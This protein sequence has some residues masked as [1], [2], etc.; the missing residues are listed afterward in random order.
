MK[1]YT[2]ILE[3]VGHCPV[4]PAS[5]WICRIP[6]D[7]WPQQTPVDGKLRPAMVTDLEWEGFLEHT[8]YLDHV[9]CYLPGWVDLEIYN[10]MISVVMP[11]QEI[12]LHSDV[13][14][15]EWLGRIHIPLATNSEAFIFSGNMRLHLKVGRVYLFSTEHPHR[16]WNEGDTPR[17]HLMFDVKS[18]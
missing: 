16:V 15:K 17:I 3:D 6:F 18:S 13:Q 12:E 11:G 4:A 9:L 5:E 1:R 7:R 8:I 2:G 10:R 14:G